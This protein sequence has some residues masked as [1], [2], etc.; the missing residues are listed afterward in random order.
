MVGHGIRTCEDRTGLSVHALT[1]REEQTLA[2]RVVLVED[3]SLPHEALVHQRR[4][5]DLHA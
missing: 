3:A 4:V 1:I 2:R 5:A